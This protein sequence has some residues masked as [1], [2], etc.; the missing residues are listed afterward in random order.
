MKTSS[1]INIAKLIS[2]LLVFFF[3]KKNICIKRNGL[4]WNL[5]LNEAIDLSIYLTG[6]FEPSI[7]NI[8]KTL[9]ENENYDYIDIGANNGAH[10]LYLA[11]K[12]TKSKIYAIEPTDYSFNKL[13]KNIEL[14]PGIKN[15]IIPIQSFVTSKENKPDSVYTSWKLNSDEKK[16]SEHLGVKKSLENCTLITL[17]TL[18]EKNKIEK[19]IIKCDV[20]GNE[21]FVF[22]SGINFISK[23]KPRIIMELAP[24]LYPENGY[25]SSQLFNFFKQFGYKYF[26]VSTKKEIHDIQDFSD[27]ILTGSSKNIF[28][29]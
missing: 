15:Q 11:Q 23:F 28:L 6:R 26:E 22:E 13:L 20:D 8:I 27:A 1:K 29:I 16:H 12:F 2:R 3:S 18:A 17:D 25:K 4:N 9:S 5:D 21:L 14:N 19:S 7:F 10:S 24:Y